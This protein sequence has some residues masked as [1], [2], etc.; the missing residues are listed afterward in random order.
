MKRDGSV[1]SSLFRAAGLLFHYLCVLDV[2][3]TVIATCCRHDQHQNEVKYQ[4]RKTGGEDRHSCVNHTNHGGVNFK[5]LGDSAAYS[6]PNL[7]GIAF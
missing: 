7:I 1:E 5:I 4:A 3:L 2:V 6:C